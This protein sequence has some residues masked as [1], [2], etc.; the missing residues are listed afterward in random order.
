MNRGEGAGAWAALSRSQ[1]VV[2]LGKDC[3][4]G[5]EDDVLAAEL[6]LQFADQAG[7]NLLEFLG[8]AERHEDD[9][10]GLVASS[11]NFL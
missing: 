2:L 1:A 5:D 11:F 4:L 6:L 10:G 8:E 3:A 7:L 9:D